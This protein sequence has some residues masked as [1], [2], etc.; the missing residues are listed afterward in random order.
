MLHYRPEQQQESRPFGLQQHRQVRWR[1]GIQGTVAFMGFGN[2]GS[3]ILRG[4]LDTA[5]LSPDRA[6]VF[7]LDAQ[8]TQAASKL[9]C[10]VVSQPIDL[11]PDTVALILA[12]KPQDIAPAMESMRPAFADSTNTPLVLSVAAGI[13]IKSIQESLGVQVHVARVMPNTPALVGAGAAGIAMSDNASDQDATLAQNLFDAVGICEHVSEEMID[14]VTALSGSGPAYFFYFV[15]CMVKAAVDLGMDEN[16]AARLATQTAY[17]AGRLL[18][19]SGESAAT[20]RERVTSKGGTTAAAL[21]ALDEHGF[22]SAISAALQAA[23]KRS[24]QLGA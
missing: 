8:K 4:L 12:T 19:D 21:S 7:D 1:V 11:V 10:T 6:K 5:A 24:Q 14:A 16:Q 20:L 23:A 15:E 9:G 22:E 18:K 3:A 2:M 13:S 17:G